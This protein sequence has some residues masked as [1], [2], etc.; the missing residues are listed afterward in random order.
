MSILSFKKY[1]DFNIFKMA[2]AMTSLPKITEMAVARLIRQIETC[3]WCQNVGIGVWN[4]MHF[5][6]LKYLERLR[7]YDLYR[8]LRIH[9]I[10]KLQQLNKSHFCTVM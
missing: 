6:E 7:R 9:I 8:E 1:I 10:V 3:K 2:A 4:P 5:T